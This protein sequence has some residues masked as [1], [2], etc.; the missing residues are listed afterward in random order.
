M[1][2][3]TSPLD[4]VS[5]LRCL[6]GPPIEVLLRGHL[7]VQQRLGALLQEVLPFPGQLDLDRMT[8]PAMARLGSALGLANLGPDDLAGLLKLNVLRNRLAHNLD[9]K[10]DAAC[11]RELYDALSSKARDVAF[12]DKALDDFESP[13]QCSRSSPAWSSL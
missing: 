13:G 4:T 9:W 10:P 7:F 6:E 12:G 8:Y 11:E 3:R 2:N 1:P 5:L